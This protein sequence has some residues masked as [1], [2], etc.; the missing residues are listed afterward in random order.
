MEK[1][2]LQSP[3]S[4]H[5][6]WKSQLSVT[7]DLRIAVNNMSAESR[8]AATENDGSSSASRGGRTRATGWQSRLSA[9]H[10]GRNFDD[11]SDNW[12][13]PG[14]STRASGYQSRK[15]Y[16][17]GSRQQNSSSYRRESPGT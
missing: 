10:R 1:F 14:N 7:V 4:V 9:G 8:W 12:R 17:S 3:P 2:S 13:S 16:G 11:R 6:P 15:D 5:F